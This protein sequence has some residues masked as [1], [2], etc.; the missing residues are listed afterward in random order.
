MSDGQIVSLIIETTQ[1]KPEAT[2]AR[3][4]PMTGPHVATVTRQNGLD[5]IAET[6]SISGD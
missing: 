2:L 6:R 3:R 4:C 1:R 5:L